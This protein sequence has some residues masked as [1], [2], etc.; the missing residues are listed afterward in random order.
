VRG[1]RLSLDKPDVFNVQLRALAR[2]AVHGNLKVMFPM[3]T[4]P[5]ELE[6][7]KKLFNEQVDMLKAS[8]IPC[9]IPAL[10]MMVEVPAAALQIAEFK[11]DFY[12][13][14]S[15]DLIQYVMAAGRDTSG[16]GYLQDGLN[17]AVLE[18]I[19]RVAKH[20]LGHAIEVSVC[21]EMASQAKAI[22]AL[23]DVGINVLSVPASSLAWVK[24]ELAK[25]GQK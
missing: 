6:R 10:G 1:L 23:L 21:G 2:A 24:V 9:T 13:I 16:L 19:E 7:A 15:N 11:A 22:P 25:Y 8:G 14:G 4:L 3:V 17:P 20:G 18:L 5:S 12:S